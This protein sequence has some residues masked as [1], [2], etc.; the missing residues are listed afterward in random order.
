MGRDLITNLKFKKF[1]G[2]FNPEA[3]SEMVQ[4]AY[5]ANRNMEKWQQKKTFSPSTIGYGYGTCPRYW[6]I[7]FSGT[8]FEDTFDALA[9]ASMENGKQAHDRIQKII[10]STPVFKELEREILSEDPPIRGFADL[11]IDWSG[12]DVIGELKT[13]KQEIFSMRQAEMAPTTSHLVQLLIYMWVEKIDEGFVM[14]ENKNNNEIL[15]MPIK[16]NERNKKIV[17]EI[18]DWMREVHGTWKKGILPERVY[19][20]SS[21]Q[22]KSC[23]V[24]RFCW[25]EEVG[26]IRIEKLNLPK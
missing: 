20:K 26:D 22:C 11:V 15:I 16:M 4:D 17:E 7:A 3:F 8:E 18:V 10:Q 5:M 1:S 24:R 6:F 13:V 21:Y 2:N 14:Y 25:S 12:I 9:I 23:P 19:T